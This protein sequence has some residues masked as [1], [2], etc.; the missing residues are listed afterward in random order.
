MLFNYF[1]FRL[2]NTA[3]QSYMPNQETKLLPSMTVCPLTGYKAKGKFFNMENYLNNTFE[4]EQVFSPNTIE[5]LKNE[6]LYSVK[7][8]YSILLGRCFRVTRYEVYI[9]FS[10]VVDKIQV[11]KL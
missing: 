11:E 5:M 10:M 8:V 3:I 9:Y 4:K 7:E 6:S 1:Y 2:S